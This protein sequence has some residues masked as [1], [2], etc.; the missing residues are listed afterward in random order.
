MNNT[1]KLMIAKHALHVLLLLLLY[2]LQT[3]PGLFVLFGVKP[4][5]VIP[6]AIALAM[7]EGEFAGGIY[8][9]L[10]GLLCDTGGFSLFGFNG[11]ITAICCMAAGLLVFHLMRCNLLSCML[12]VL[13][14]LFLRGSIEYFFSFGMWNYENALS[15]YTRFTLPTVLYSALAAPFSFW[16]VR[17]IHRRFKVQAD[18]YFE[19]R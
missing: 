12:F 10:A 18:S 7:F 2:V 11:F 9:A 8:G 16:M 15:L 19:D 17:G 4:I 1:R 13:V 3:V 5:L 14:T 6:A